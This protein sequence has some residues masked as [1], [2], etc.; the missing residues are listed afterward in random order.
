[1]LDANSYR[2]NIKFID[3]ICKNKTEERRLKDL[4][5]VAQACG[6]H[7]ILVTCYIGEL[8]GFTDAVKNKIDS[9]KKFYKIE[10]IKGVKY[11]T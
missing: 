1:M 9:L 2:N 6:V 8:Y 7:I 5:I 11:G 4:T 10:D 3:D